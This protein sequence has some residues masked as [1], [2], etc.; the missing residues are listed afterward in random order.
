MSTP[1][2]DNLKVVLLGNSGV[3]KSNLIARFHNDEFSNEFMS[4]IGV[5]F[6]TKRIEVDGVPV[7]LQIWDTAGQE[8]YASMMKTYY[9]KAKGAL[10]VYDVT[11]P[12]SFQGLETWKKNLEANADPSCVSIIVGNKTDMESSVDQEAVEALAQEGGMDVMMTSAKNGQG[13]HEA[14]IALARKIISKSG[15]GARSVDEGRRGA[16]AKDLSTSSRNGR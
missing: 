11:A 9:R 10:L 3:G 13:V 7:R 16:S 8:R 6:V 4:T 2:L 5:E 1:G 14:F 15:G 12:A